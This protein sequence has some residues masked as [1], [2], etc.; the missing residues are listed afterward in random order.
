[1]VP[2]KEFAP[3]S[4][5]FMTINLRCISLSTSNEALP[6]SIPDCPVHLA[7]WGQHALI[8]GNAPT[9]RLTVIVRP[10]RSTTPVVKPACLKA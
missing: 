7:Q 4:L 5:E 9:G 1:M 3:L 10:T 2:W 6:A 8:C